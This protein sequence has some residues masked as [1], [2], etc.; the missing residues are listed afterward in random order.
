MGRKKI[1]DRRHF[2]QATEPE[3]TPS[4]AQA[5]AMAGPIPEVPPVT[6]VTFPANKFTIARQY[7]GIGSE[8]ELRYHPIGFTG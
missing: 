4:S 8:V 1:Q 3:V 2:F 7:A 6:R 5:I